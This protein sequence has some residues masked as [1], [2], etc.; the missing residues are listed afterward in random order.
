MAEFAKAIDKTR[1]RHYLIADTEDEINS[2]CEKIRNFKSTKV[3]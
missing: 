1:V 2:Y 3:C